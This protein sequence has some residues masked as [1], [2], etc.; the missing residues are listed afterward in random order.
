MS[1][2]VDVT[3]TAEPDVVDD[4]SEPISIF[5]GRDTW[6]PGMLDHW[7][8]EVADDHLRLILLNWERAL[9]SHP[10]M[11]ALIFSRSMNRSPRSTT[12]A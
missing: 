7:L 11:A 2:D 5:A 4:E 3:T 9:H 1:F 12:S 10:T 8:R 6:S